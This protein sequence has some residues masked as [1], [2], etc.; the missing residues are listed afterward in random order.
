MATRYNLLRRMVWIKDK[1]CVISDGAKGIGFGIAK[2]WAREG[3][4]SVILSRLTMDKDLENEFKNLYENF[5]FYQIDLKEYE[6]IKKLIGEI[7]QKYGLI[8]AL[9][10]NADANDNLHIKNS[11]TKDL[12]KFYENNLFHYYT[13]AKECLP[14]IKKEKGSVLVSQTALI[15]QN[16]C[17]RLSKSRS[18]RLYKRVACAFAKNEVRTNALSPAEVITSLYEKWL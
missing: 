3:G 8:Y 10:N 4:I 7:Y 17:L 11:S 15:R 2:L 16:E 9:V 14:Y 6:K 13:L 5:G 1:V 18:N 12:I